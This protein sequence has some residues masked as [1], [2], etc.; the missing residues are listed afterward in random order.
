MNTS[1]KLLNRQLDEINDELDAWEEEKRMH[2]SPS[3]SQNPRQAPPGVVRPSEPAN[4]TTTTTTEE[5]VPDTPSMP[6]SSNQTV[7]FTTIQTRSL[8]TDE[9]W[10]NARDDAHDPEIPP[11]VRNLIHLRGRDRL[12][13]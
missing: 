5:K 7:K 4:N 3:G 11:L 8:G 12:L 13:R 9:E 1:H 6:G 10:Q 2:S